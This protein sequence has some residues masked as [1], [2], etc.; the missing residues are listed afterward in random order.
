M[1]AAIHIPFGL[2]IVLPAVGP[3]IELYAPKLAAWEGF[4]DT[5]DCLLRRLA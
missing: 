4:A 1:S 3:S 2:P 5:K